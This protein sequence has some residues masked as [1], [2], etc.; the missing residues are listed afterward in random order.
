L[1]VMTRLDS[2]NSFVTEF[3]VQIFGIPFGDYYF[4]FQCDYTSTRTDQ[5]FFRS[6]SVGQITEDVSAPQLVE[7]NVNNDQICLDFNERIDPELSLEELV[8]QLSGELQEDIDFE[9]SQIKLNS[10][11]SLP[12]GTIDVAITGL[13]DSNGNRLDT[14]FSIFIPAQAEVGDIVINELL[15]DPVSDGEDFLELLNNSDKIFD[16]EGL[17]ILNTAS[18][19]SE[20]IDRSIMMMPG[21]IVAFSENIDQLLNFYPSANPEQIY[22]QEL[23]SFVNAGGNVSLDMNGDILDS[24][25][26]DDDLH[27]P[28]LD[29]TEAVSLERRDANLPSD[30]TS[31]WASASENAGFATPG[32][33]NSSLNIGNVS[34]DLLTLSS[35]S[36]SPN[37]DGDNDELE[38]TVT[39]LA[40]S[41]GTIVIYDQ[42]G[43]LVL[44]L[45]NNVLLG[46][47]DTIT[48]DGRMEN[49]NPAS[50]GIYILRVQV[51]DTT[52]RV[53]VIKKAVAL[54][55]F[56]E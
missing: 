43:N 49:G 30:Q 31:T 26:F 47:Q 29:D 51:F 25:D 7:T 52:G 9:G 20:T 44:T 8:I 27:H 48:W 2:E 13:S 37:G 46:S 53:S 16:L 12:V 14:L 34:D 3:N 4:G 21:E 5:F 15:F 45:K 23:P 40:N 28:L 56:L 38:I 22:N 54:V 6:I 24:F 39:P 36:F 17:V 42:S 10:D 33:A 1:T 18:G 11:G 19:N 35:E 55:D 32:A 41:I 50:I